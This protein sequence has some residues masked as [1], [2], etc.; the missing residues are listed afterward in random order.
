MPIGR[1]QSVPDYSLVD[2]TRCSR[3]EPGFGG[4]KDADSW[5]P[6]HQGA[7]HR[8]EELSDD[9]LAAIEGTF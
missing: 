3:S 8:A 2:Q 6:L 9:V 4:H 5:N 1:S 7:L